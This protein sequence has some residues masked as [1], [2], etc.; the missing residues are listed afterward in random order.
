[1]AASMV[2]LNLCCTYVK[3]CGVNGKVAGKMAKNVEMVQKYCNVI[4]TL[5]AVVWGFYSYMRLFSF[6][7]FLYLLLVMVVVAGGGVCYV[8]LYCLM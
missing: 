2:G 5:F 7:Y 4:P 1:M 6:S 3:G 8:I